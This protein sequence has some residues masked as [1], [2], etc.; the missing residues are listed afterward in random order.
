MHLSSRR[1]FSV[2]KEVIFENSH[3]CH[4]FF[5]LLGIVLKIFSGRVGESGSSGFIDLGK[6]CAR[7]VTA[8][9]ELFESDFQTR[10]K[11][12]TNCHIHLLE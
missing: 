11:E 3:A 6:G 4:V 7:A 9:Y 1:Y 8:I 2:S 5:C 10:T 12:H